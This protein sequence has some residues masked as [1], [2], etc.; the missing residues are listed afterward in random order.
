LR[1]FSRFPERILTQINE[2][3]HQNLTSTL[4]KAEI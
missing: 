4:G 3:S 2:I 1:R